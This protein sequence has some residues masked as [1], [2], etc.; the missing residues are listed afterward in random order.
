MSVNADL[1]G[2][3][4]P[5]APPYSVG[6][7]GIRA[8]AAAVKATHPVHS[9]LDAALAAG[10]ADLVAPPTFA[11]V[12]AQNAEGAYIQDPESG[13]DFARV[14]HAE[15]RFTHHR[16][17]VAGDQITATVSVERARAVGTG[18]MVV[19]RTELVGAD[20]EPVTTVLSTLMVRGED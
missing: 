6:R 12:I 16:A 19:T 4:Y 2:R 18:G 3:V 8:F 13:I 5:P 20:G 9:D 1:Q 11:V 15:E 10:H 17:I 14:V 7:E